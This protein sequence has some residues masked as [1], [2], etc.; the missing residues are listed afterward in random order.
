MVYPPPP[1][2]TSVSKRRTMDKFE[3]FTRNELIFIFS[4]ALAVVGLTVASIV[5]F[6]MPIGNDGVE[7]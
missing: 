2:T 3:K 1:P 4:S 6:V 5:M 7:E